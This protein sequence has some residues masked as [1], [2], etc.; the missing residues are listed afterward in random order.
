MG[1]VN[2]IGGRGQ[3]FPKSNFKFKKIFIDRFT[4]SH[5][6]ILI[7]KNPNILFLCSSR[8]LSKIAH[9]LEEAIIKDEEVEDRST[10]KDEVAS[11]IDFGSRALDWDC[12]RSFH[13]N[14]AK[15]S[16]DF[17]DEEGM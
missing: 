9:F 4:L 13:M 6:L 3:N 8:S 17:G 16:D 12:L 2:K 5:I 1:V 14:P 7:T 10:G 11:E 15:V